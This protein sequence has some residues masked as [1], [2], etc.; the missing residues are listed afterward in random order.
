[1]VKTSKN[2]YEDE[3]NDSELLDEDEIDY[4]DEDQCEE[5]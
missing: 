2:P 4:Y 5:E 3:Y 1:M